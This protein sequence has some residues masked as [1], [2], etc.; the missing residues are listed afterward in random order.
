MVGAHRFGRYGCVWGSLCALGA[1]GSLQLVSR[2]AARF[3]AGSPA[4]LR[5]LAAVLTGSVVGGIAGFA[6]L[7]SVLHTDPSQLIFIAIVTLVL[8]MGV[9]TRRGRR[10]RILGEP[11]WGGTRSEASV[12]E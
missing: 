3:G 8:M 1:W 6:S 11:S 4:L 7:S 9:V 10:T 12:G 5:E 2:V